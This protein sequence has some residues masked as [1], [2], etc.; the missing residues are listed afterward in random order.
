MISAAKPGDWQWEKSRL[1][2]PHYFHNLRKLLHCRGCGFRF[3]V[4]LYAPRTLESIFFV[5]SNLGIP[6][7]TT[8]SCGWMT[9]LGPAGLLLHSHHNCVFLRHE[10]NV[11]RSDRYFLGDWP[12]EDSINIHVKRLGGLFIYIATSYHYIEDANQWHSQER[13]SWI[14]ES[15]ISH[16][17]LSAHGR[18]ERHVHAFLKMFQ[19]QRFLIKTTYFVSASGSWHIVGSMIGLFDVL[20]TIALAGLLDLAVKDDNLIEFCTC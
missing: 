8:A 6:A 4:N 17:R 5:R 15:D 11:I 14:L 10:L 19:D 20:S 9:W 13:F 3:G 2:E 12:D 18:I 7:M 1:Q 16:H